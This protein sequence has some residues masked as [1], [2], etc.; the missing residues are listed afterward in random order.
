[1]LARLPYGFRHKLYC[2]LSPADVLHYRLKS[3][4]FDDIKDDDCRHQ[5]DE[6][7]KK[8][9]NILIFG[10]KEIDFVT[11]PSIMP[12]L[13]CKDELICKKYINACCSSLRCMPAY[14][15]ESRSHYYIPKRSLR[16]LTFPKYF[17]HGYY[18]GFDYYRSSSRQLLEYCDAV[19]GPRKVEL[20]FFYSLD[21]GL[22]WQEFK[23][24]LEVHTRK[25]FNT[26]N[27]V[28]NIDPALPFMQKY[29]ST[30]E[31][32]RLGSFHSSSSDYPYNVVETNKMV[33]F[34]VLYNI[35]TCQQPRLKHIEVYGAPDAVVDILTNVVKLCTE[36]DQSPV[37]SSLPSTAFKL[38][39]V[40]RPL[41]PYILK[42]LS[43]SLS[44]SNLLARISELI[45]NIV[46]FQ[47][48]YL[49]KVSI[50]ICYSRNECVQFL[51]LLSVLTELLKR[52]QLRFM[53]VSV[54][55]PEVCSMI[56]TFL[57]TETTHD[58]TLRVE[59][60]YN[61]NDGSDPICNKMKMD[62]TQPLPASNGTFKTLDIHCI[63]HRLHAWLFSIPNLQLK[64][65]RTFKISL[66]PDNVGFPVTESMR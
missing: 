29:F 61:D 52:P 19:T 58:Q 30:A 41:T 65:L 54:S 10:E 23:N 36:C 35:V 20:N 3:N 15:D 18:E 17:Q 57:F 7:N 1:M 39:L 34:V 48:H 43:V 59:S 25:F 37:C 21:G 9:L 26:E 11:P 56:E 14:S 31:I 53:S 28:L 40:R 32:V 55:P 62:S 13:K 44:S 16:Y 2:C 12:L 4:V 27:T 46:S 49:E 24:I 6:A 51:A 42:S 66:V 38:V 50:A 33:S 63:S 8:L 45:M 64:E 60:I 47:L 22:L 5:L